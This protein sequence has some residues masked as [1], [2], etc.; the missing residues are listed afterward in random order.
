MTRSTIGRVVKLLEHW[1]P[2][3]ACLSG[4]VV[5]VSPMI[6]DAALSDFHACPGLEAQLL[7]ILEFVRL[8]EKRWRVRAPQRWFVN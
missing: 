1:L 5:P 7:E 4:T 2:Y 6:D 3:W 8:Q